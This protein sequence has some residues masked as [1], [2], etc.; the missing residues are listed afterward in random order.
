MQNKKIDI[1]LKD[2]KGFYCYECSTNASKTCKQ[3]KENYLHGIGKGLNQ[4]QVKVSF[5]K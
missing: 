3:A 5:S 2:L 1:Y 4:S